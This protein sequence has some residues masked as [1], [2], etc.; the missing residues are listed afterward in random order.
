MDFG[1]KLKRLR[2]MKGLTQAEFAEQIGRTQG[3]VGLYERGARKPSIEVLEKIASVFGVDPNYLLQDSNEKADY[4]EIVKL[5][6][7]Y[8][9]YADLISMGDS[10]QE[11][12]KKERE[13]LEKYGDMVMR[14]TYADRIRVEDF[15]QKI[16]QEGDY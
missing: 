9:D 7:E 1:T 8:D 3:A 16:R 6:G 10:P 2:T 5:T 12:K 11:A 4:K 14:L 13:R 15:I